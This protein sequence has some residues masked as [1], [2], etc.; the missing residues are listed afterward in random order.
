MKRGIMDI[1]AAL[2]LIA[3]AAFAQVGSANPVIPGGGSGGSGTVGGTLAAED[4]LVVR[5]DGTGGSTIQASALRLADTTGDLQWEGTTA[6]AFEGNFTFADPTA[7]WTWAWGAAGDLVGAGSLSIDNLKLDGNTIS[8][9]DTNGNIV[10]AP[11][12]SGKVGVPVGSLTAPGI[13]VNGLSGTGFT[14]DEGSQRG[15]S[16]TDSNESK[17]WIGTGDV[18]M[19]SDY[20][21]GW[22]SSSSNA[23]V[24]VNDTGLSRGAAGVVEITDGPT[25]AGVLHLRSLASPPRT[26]DGTAE[27][28]F[29]RDTSHALCYCDGAAWQVLN[30]LTAGVGTCS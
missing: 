30:P 21:I 2:A 24:N 26:C 4:N 10:L 17:F 1:F 6:D 5:T 11:N 25:G 19:Q 18:R 20:N 9:T 27:G 8:S 14:F 29:Y 22:T 7:D 28:D 16:W 23:S 12:G 15:V 13:F 3:G